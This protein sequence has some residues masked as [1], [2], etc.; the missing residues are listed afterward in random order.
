L[1][2]QVFEP[3]TTA[4][5]RCTALRDG[6]SVE[7]VRIDAMTNREARNSLEQLCPML[8]QLLDSVRSMSNDG[9]VLTTTPTEDAAEDSIF[10]TTL[11][12]AQTFGQQLSEIAVS[13]TR[14][15]RDT[16]WATIGILGLLLGASLLIVQRHNREMA[17]LVRR[18]TLLLEAAG[19]SIYGL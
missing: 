13:D 17:R 8:Q 12:S 6:G 3:L 11:S 14:I 1:R 18:N 10:L 4:V 7:S 2:T 16:D 9:N 19:D 15:I 5:G